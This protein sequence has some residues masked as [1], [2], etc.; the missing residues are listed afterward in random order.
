MKYPDSKGTTFK[1]S[2]VFADAISTANESYDASTIKT[3][4]SN[5]WKQRPPLD[6]SYA[7]TDEAFP[8]LPK[9]QTFSP[10]TQS[11]SSETI[12]EMTLQSAI[13]AAIKTLQEQ[14]RIDLQ[15]L[16]KEMQQKMESLENQMLELGKQVVYQTYQALV[17]ED[18]PLVTKTDHLQLQHEMT[19][20]NAQLST[21]IQM[22]S[23]NQGF[24][25]A[26]PEPRPPDATSP[27]R[28]NKRLK[29]NRTPEKITYSS[30]PFTQDDNSLPSAT[31]DPLE[32]GCEG[33]ED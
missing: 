33:C 18:S 10:A 7:P 25:S 12:D 23:T 21:L 4:R 2:A 9:S 13:S 11:T 5:A 20:I 17:T 14:H 27:P 16:R 3:T 8:P 32:E 24:R 15:E 31:S 28:T 19:A 30:E 26:T 1:Y 22:V 6:I 29:Q